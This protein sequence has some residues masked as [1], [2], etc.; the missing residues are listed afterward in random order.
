[1]IKLTYDKKED[2]P[3]GLESHYTEKNGKFSLQIDGVKTQADVDNVKEALRKERADHDEAKAA[4]KEANAKLAGATD[5]LEVLKSNGGKDDRE[6]TNEE[7]IRLRQL[8]REVATL[9]TERD[10]LS[11][12]HSELTNKVTTA[13]LRDQLRKDAAK[14]VR[15]D[16]ID[17]VVDMVLPNFG[18][19]DDKV[20][21]KAELGD[22][23]GLSG[24][25]FFADHVK[26]RQFLAIPSN[27]GGAK[28]G[29]GQG[30]PSDS[31]TPVS[32]TEFYDGLLSGS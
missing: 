12:K 21:T 9:T 25:E 10:E 17:D 7:L 5:E 16:A 32:K 14:H 30:T 8:E 31:D 24:E 22:K 26:S 3:A 6:P 13:R 2:I 20:L 27:S 4:L 11:T 15:P 1:M 18:I 19:S 28:G 29:T 23:G